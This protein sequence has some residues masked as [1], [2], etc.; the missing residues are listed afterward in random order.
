MIHDVV[1]GGVIVSGV[2]RGIKRL[3]LL[4]HGIQDRTSAVARFAS[5]DHVRRNDGT[6]Q[7]A[8]RATILVPILMI[9]DLRA[10]T[11]KGVVFKDHRLR[12]AA[13]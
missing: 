3:L 1:R 5:N 11:T 7:G 6:I 10:A 4:R 8:S 12:N 2:R 9:S 13:M